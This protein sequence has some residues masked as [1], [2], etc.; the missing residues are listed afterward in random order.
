[1]FLAFVLVSG[2]GAPNWPMGEEKRKKLRQ[3]MSRTVESNE[4]D[5]IEYQ[6]YINRSETKCI[7]HETCR[8]S[9]SIPT[10]SRFDVY[11]NPSEELRKVLSC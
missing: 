1:M 2:S 3:D 5:T 9:S 10:I 6:F 7:V 4:P 8:R 11:G